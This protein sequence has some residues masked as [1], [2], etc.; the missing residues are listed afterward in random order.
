[1]RKGPEIYMEIL[2]SLWTNTKL[3]IHVMKLDKEHLLETEQLPLPGNK[4]TACHCSHKA[5]RWIVKF[6]PSRI[7]AS[8]SQRPPKCHALGIGL[9]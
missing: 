3:H 8:A 5:E 4:T 9:L 1:M 7:E 6:Q 2:L